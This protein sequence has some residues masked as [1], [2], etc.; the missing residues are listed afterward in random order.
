MKAI[1][2]S[3]F[4]DHGICLTEW[5]RIVEQWCAAWSQISGKDDD[6]L[7]TILRNGQLNAGRSNHV[8]GVNQTRLNPSRD[9]ERLVVFDRR[10]Q[11]PKLVNVCL[12]EQRLEWR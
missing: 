7:A 9:F 6:L 8:T 12:L 1:A 3:G 4:H 11:W 2:V 5:L 10:G